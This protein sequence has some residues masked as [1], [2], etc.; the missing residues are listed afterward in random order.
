[1]AELKADSIEDLTKGINPPKEKK[2]KATEVKEVKEEAS[3]EAKT[4][5]KTTEKKIPYIRP[6]EYCQGIGNCGIQG[7]FR[8]SSWNVYV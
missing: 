8:Q 3:K 5:E 6:V 1:M 7:E 2:E 4:S